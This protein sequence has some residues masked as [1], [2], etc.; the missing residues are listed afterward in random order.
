MTAAKK[1]DW[2][3]DTNAGPIVTRK[4]LTVAEMKQYTERGCP[5]THKRG[6][7]VTWHRHNKW[8]VMTVFNSKGRKVHACA[9][10]PE[11]E[12]NKFRPSAQSA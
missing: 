10:L 12:F 11:V 4:D 1:G 2:V 7:T 9:F 6:Y 8:Y 3:L 5:L